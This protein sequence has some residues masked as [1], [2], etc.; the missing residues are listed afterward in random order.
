M[1]GSDRWRPQEATPHGL[2]RGTL[3]RSGTPGRRTGLFESPPS[4][5][6]SSGTETWIWSVHTLRD[7]EIWIIQ[8]KFVLSIITPADSWKMPDLILRR[9]LW[10]WIYLPSMQ[11]LR[12]AVSGLSNS[13]FRDW[14]TVR[15]SSGSAETKHP[16]LVSRG[17]KKTSRHLV[18][19]LQLK[20]Q[21]DHSFWKGFRIIIIYSQS[22]VY[23]GTNKLFTSRCA[24]PKLRS[25]VRSN[26]LE[27]ECAL[28]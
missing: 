14:A 3:G 6:H 7:K 18:T 19:F 5:L 9:A 21:D 26:D 8:N 28:M 23:F 2:C 16:T 15:K 13:L 27:Q 24:D 12:S 22:N 17:C 4:C 1:C 10:T 25:D 11:N 20:T